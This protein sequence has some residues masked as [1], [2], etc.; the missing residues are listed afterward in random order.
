MVLKEIRRANR[1]FLITVA[2]YVMG[3]L[4]I[5]YLCRYV[6][7]PYNLRVM[8]GQILIGLSL[9]GFFAVTRTSPFK[10][11]RHAGLNITDILLVVLLMALSMPLVYLINYI[12]MM[13]TENEIA[14]TMN[15]MIDNPFIVNLLMIAVCP[16]IIEETVCRGIM[17]HAYRKKSVPAA[18]FLSALLFGLLHM[19]LNQMLYAVVMG[20]IFALAVEATGSIYASM[21]MHFLMNGFSVAM[22]WLLKLLTKSGIYNTDML[23]QAGALRQETEGLAASAPLMLILLL[24]ALLIVTATTVGTAGVLLL[25]AK[26]KNRLAEF[27]EMFGKGR[28]NK[29]TAG[30]VQTEEPGDGLNAEEKHIIDLCFVLSVIICAGVM[31]FW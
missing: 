1:F 23:E 6:A 19:N 14:Q 29:E 2:V 18:V 11:I 9:A 8:S 10:F 3:S 30:A 12:S 25:L 22:L 26:R 4:G 7:L 24:I 21:I 16:A 31:I 13:F 17:L 20:I 27:K 5:A 28:G 15:G